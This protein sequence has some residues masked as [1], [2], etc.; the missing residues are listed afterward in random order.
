MA[1]ASNR[2]PLPGPTPRFSRPWRPK[3]EA[4][5]I[6]RFT[7]ERFAQLTP[8]L[9]GPE[10]L[11]AFEELPESLQAAAWAALEKQQRQQHEVGG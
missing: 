11:A 5:A 4:A 6:G 8:R 7:F 9:S 3:T 2:V 10:R 1:G